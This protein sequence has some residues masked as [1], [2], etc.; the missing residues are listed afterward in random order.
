MGYGT[1]AASAVSLLGT[2]TSSSRHTF[3]STGQWNAFAGLSIAG[4]VP[5]S[6]ALVVAHLTE[7]HVASGANNIL[8]GY[9]VDG[10]TPEFSGAH[11]ATAGAYFTMGFS[12]P[13]TLTA[14]TRTIVAGRDHLPNIG[15][16]SGPL[17]KYPDR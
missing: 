12:K 9:S 14:G 8:V 6:T 7:G 17:N 1:N 13:V 3:S 15:G 16:S 2:A 11:Y 5:N 4:T 10:G